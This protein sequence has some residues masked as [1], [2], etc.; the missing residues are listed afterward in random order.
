MVK[1]KLERAS[2]KKLSLKMALYGTGGA[3]KT[4]TALKIASELAGDK[5]FGLIESENRASEKYCST[6][7]G[8]DG[9][10]DF[11]IINLGNPDKPDDISEYTPEQYIQAL[12]MF[13]AEGITTVIIDSLSHPYLRSLDEVNKQSVRFK[14]NTFVAWKDVTPRYNALMRYITNSGMNIICT[15]R[16]KTAYELEA[17][18]KGRSAPKA[19]GLEPIIRNGFEYEFDIVGRME[20]AT[21][22]ITKTRCFELNNGVYQRPGKD[23]ATIIKRWLGT[24]ISEEDEKKAQ[25]A[26]RIVEYQSLLKENG[27]EVKDI[28]LN[29]LS[30]EELT[31]LGR[32]LKAQL[33]KLQETK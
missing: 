2:R 18:E 17:N 5:P 7:G 33:D 24:G 29:T 8:E 4:Y 1:L 15:L 13:K 12:E 26:Q 11:Y 3:G 6:N 21:L 28:D 22:V 32:S 31:Q 14:G 30:V 10:F 20:D 16:A 19:V 23:F 25:Y 9:L 27:Q